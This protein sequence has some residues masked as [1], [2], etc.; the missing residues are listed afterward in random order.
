MTWT[1][2]PIIPFDYHQ[3]HLAFSPAGKTLQG[4]SNGIKM[5]AIRTLN[6]VLQLYQDIHDAAKTEQIIGTTTYLLTE[7]S[8][9]LNLGV[10][11][12]Q[13]LTARAIWHQP[14]GLRTAIRIISIY[15]TAAVRVREYDVERADAKVPPRG[16]G[17]S[18]DDWTRA[19]VK[20][21]DDRSRRWKHLL[22]LTGVLMG[23]VNNEEGMAISRSL[24]NTLEGAV[25]TAANLALESHVED[26]PLAAA[27]IVMALNFTFPLLSDL[28]KLQINYDALLPISVWSVAGEEGFVHGEF[29][30]AIQR[31]T[32][33]A[34][35]NVWNW[36]ANA[37]SVQLL[38][39]MGN[40]P[41]LANIGPLSKLIGFAVQHTKNPRI[42]LEAQNTLFMFSRRL[43]DAWQATAFSNIDSAEEGLRLSP[44]TLSTAWPALWLTL[45]KLMFCVVAVLQTIVS[46][47]IIDPSMI[48]DRAASRI[49]STS[50]HILRN[51]FFVSSRD[52]NSAFQVYTFTY[53]TS[54]DVISRD[55]AAAKTF[56]SE[57]RPNDANGLQPGHLRRTLDL[58]YLNLAE[59]LPLTL[60]TSTCD[61]LIIKP[62]LAYLSHDGALS[63]FMIQLFE[64]AHSAALSV[65]SCPQ[66]GSLTTQLAPFYIDK[67]LESFPHHTS[68][69]QFR[70]AF[71]TIMQIVSPPFP[72]AAKE[73]H[74][75]ETLLEMLHYKMQHAS[76]TPLPSTADAGAGDSLPQSAEPLSEQST[77]G[78]ALIDSLPFLP[79]QL[80]EEWLTVTAQALNYIVDPVLR[81][82][83]KKRFWDV[84]VSG[85]MDLERAAI[86]V[87]WWG[88]KG[89][90]ELILSSSAPSQTYMMSGALVPEERSSRL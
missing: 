40:R 54:I 70:V 90:R 48:N 38:Q 28:H 55:M 80:V 58:F 39:E 67:L 88:T 11:T 14:D 9:P 8:N 65:M 15:N 75:S 21:A 35:E 69:R 16:G 36:P 72:V 45:R 59:H 2:R 10:L 47:S 84:L 56:L 32:V 43:F 77:L 66:H 52:G 76:T 61:E 22:V 20:G 41:L 87:A 3:P 29:L 79:L 6:N 37:P 27:S 7:L 68:P 83:V 82:V 57:T 46:R 19:V 51:L 86:G 24:R 5:S 81:E 73:P 64:S 1:F 85:E 60:P 49:A 25:V 74:L 62:S 13:I 31:D 17:L 78:L 44:E 12:S 4:R 42:V 50:L 53:M 33:Q 71:K 18:C 63:P 89:G 23:M 30:G 34:S 26:G